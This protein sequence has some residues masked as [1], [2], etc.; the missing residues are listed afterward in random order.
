M[1]NGTFVSGGVIYLETDEEK[2]LLELKKKDDD[3]QKRT[4]RMFGLMSRLEQPKNYN[5]EEIDFDNYKREESDPVMEEFKRRQ[6]KKAEAKIIS[7]DFFSYQPLPKIR[8]KNKKNTPSVN[9]NAVKTLRSLA[10]DEFR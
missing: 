10:S 7:E 4:F 3:K 1:E 6:T 9:Q 2:A 8:R 5:Y